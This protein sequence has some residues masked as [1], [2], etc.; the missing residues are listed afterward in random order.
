MKLSR[1]ALA[2]T[3]LPTSLWADDANID[4]SE[5]LQA[6]ALVISS[7]RKAE[8]R[9]QATTAN[10]VFTRADIERLQPASVP[11]LLQR[12]PGVQVVQSGGRGSNVSLFIRGTGTAQSLVLIDG[13][14]TG[15]VSAGGASLQHLSI[16][17]IERIEVLRGSR[18]A[19]YGADTIGGVVQ[20]FTRRAEGPGLQPRLRLAAGSQGTWERSMGLSGGDQQT[21]FS[22][23]ASLDET[24]GIDRT[25]PSYPSDADHDA[26][27]NQAVSFTLSHKLAENLSTGLNVLDQRGKTEYDNPFGRWD[28]AW[29]V[30]P[31]KPYDHFSLSS[32]SAWLDWR[33]SELWSSRLEVGHGEDKQ[34]SFDKLFPGSEA[35]N[36]YRDSASWLNTLT[37]NDRHNLLVGADY[38]RDKLHSTTEYSQTSRWNQAG[39]IQHS[40]RGERFATELGLRHDKN[41]QYG[42]ENTFNAA[43]TLPLN[44]RNDLVLSYAE[45]FRAPT[46][47][48]LYSPASWG[49]NPDLQPERSKSY[50]LQWRSQLAEK[51]RLEASLYRT[52]VRDLIVYV[53]DPA[54]FN[55]S[56]YNVAEARINGF[57]LT[58][59]QE[60]LG[61]QHAL[62]ASIIDPRDRQT[63]HTLARRAKRTFS[64]DLDRQFGA[65]AVGASW[66]LASSSYDKLDNQTEIAGH[67]VLDLRSSW[68][69][70]P[71]LAFDMKLANLLD[72]DYSRSLYQY[73]GQDH[74]YQEEPLSVKVGLTWTPALQ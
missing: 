58:L 56:N 1:L 59:Q 65:F 18:S 44:A 47:N 31:Q 21:R 49:A 74:G 25:G 30:H 40:Y 66:R 62:G 55:G 42:S 19:L 50:E 27:R 64:Y 34:E 33:A 46:F 69:A 68:Q 70:T 37:L 53:F 3:L 41:Q 20:I 57:E 10:S 6:P 61:W 36:S 14:R 23:N 2:I 26:Y 22:L 71:E 45:G 11:E 13:Q 52:D 32:T 9:K 39:F 35:F 48:D 15:S 29:N 8:L 73:N 24:Q 54:T 17:Q 72:K 51:T 63:G 38:L 7:G 5:E 4:S 12:V 60:L 28:T 67:G 43:L 16:D